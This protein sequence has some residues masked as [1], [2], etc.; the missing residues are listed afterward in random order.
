MMYTESI[1]SETMSSVHYC[2][3]L[4]MYDVHTESVSSEIMSSVQYC[5]ELS[6]CDVHTESVSGETM[7]LVQ[8]QTPVSVDGKRLVSEVEWQLLHRE[9]S[10]YIR[11]IFK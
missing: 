10:C 1:S 9:V 5:D 6:M 11:S 2:D 7:S 4:L 3:E 8:S